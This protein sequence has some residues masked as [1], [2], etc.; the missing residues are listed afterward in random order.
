MS[1]A[2]RLLT[3][4][5]IYVLLG[6]LAPAV[7]F[8]LLPIYT[9]Y[10]DAEDYA[11]IT[12]AGIIQNIAT[13]VIGFAVNS[14]FARYFFDY[15]KDKVE[16]E[17]LYSTAL[18][19]YLITGFALIAAFSVVGEWLI[20]IAFKNDIFT[21]WG[22]GV[23]SMLSA[24]MM[25]IQ[26]VSLT[27]YRNSEK[28][29]QYAFLS[30]IFFLSVA[31]SIFYGVVVLE[32]KALGSV[33]GRFIGA[34]IP[35]MAYLIWYFRKNKFQFSIELNK[36]MMLFGLPVVPYLLI[37]ALL[38]QTDKYVIERFFDLQ[39]LGLYGFG[40]LIAT[41]NELFIN[42]LNSAISPQIYKGMGD[43]GALESGRVVNLIRI[44]V[45]SGLL[46]NTLVTVVGTLGLE[47]LV[48]E[49]YRATASFFPL[50]SAAYIPRI[51]YTSFTMSILYNKKT[52]ILPTVNILTLILGIAILLVL[53][54]VLGIYGACTAAIG[55]QVI[56]MT[57]AFIFLK[58]YSLFNRRYF[59]LQLESISAVII[60]AYLAIWYMTPVI[61]G[62]PHKNLL[63]TPL[64]L[65][66]GILA[67]SRVIQFFRNR[68]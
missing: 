11:L 6:M 61:Q 53:T 2:K 7:H 27:F 65:I 64:I 55:I 39:L 68:R 41:S 26:N 52:N 24:W 63:L 20:G 25:N 23:F 66:G 56:Q 16:L 13:N 9:I 1:Q 49:K 57:V 54:P 45:V 18:I 10:L 59:Q 19:S 36:K 40:Y 29:L 22:Y 21:Y 31:G 42:A 38:T 67:S 28:A 33:V 17:K 8:I 43:K 50:L 30:V 58:K 12:Q 5:V 15:Y 37:N 47:Y 32:L 35:V 46:M 44:Y 4:S 3:N 34:A 60:F 48:N 51:F 62:F 14:A